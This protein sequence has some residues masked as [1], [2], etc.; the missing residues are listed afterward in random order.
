MNHLPHLNQVVGGASYCDTVAYHHHHHHHPMQMS[1]QAARSIPSTVNNLTSL[2][3]S[4]ANAGGGPL[5]S[6]PQ[7]H[8]LNM[9]Q[10]TTNNYQ[11]QYIAYH[12]PPPYHQ[13]QSHPAQTQIPPHNHVYSSTGAATNQPDPLD[14]QPNTRQPY[15]ATSAYGGL[16]AVSYEPA[17]HGIAIGGHDPMYGMKPSTINTQS[18]HH[19]NM[20]PQTHQPIPTHQTMPPHHSHYHPYATAAQHH[21]PQSTYSPNHISNLTSVTQPSQASLIGQADENSP[22]EYDRKQTQQLAPGQT[23]LLYG[24]QNQTNQPAHQTSSMHQIQQNDD[25]TVPAYNQLQPLHRPNQAS[26]ADHHQNINNGNAGNNNHNCNGNSNSV[27]NHHHQPPNHQMQNANN[28]Q[29]SNN[30]VK[31]EQSRTPNSQNSV[32]NG[33]PTPP[34]NQTYPWMQLRRNAPKAAMVKREDS[35]GM[36]SRGECGDIPPGSHSLGATCSPSE[37]S[38]ASSTTSSSIIGSGNLSGSGLCNGSGPSH[39]PM[40]PNGSTTGS[41]GMVN[42]GASTSR[43]QQQTT[44]TNGNVGRTNFT[45]SQL[46]ELEKEFHTSRYLTRARRIEIAQHLNLNETQVKI[47]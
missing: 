26:S 37:L 32:T 19:Y 40:T 30:L 12:E 28:R 8:E 33:Q 39:L 43:N 35:M 5:E 46:T 42:Q 14:Q 10:T 7:P 47:W 13:H 17:S 3:S 29:H 38:S 23:I 45:N 1:H 15:H 34:G 18:S 2:D 22:E 44:T 36:M 9:S 21:H 4:S 41:N 16:T 24:N 11:N 27:N 20:V 6:T 25:Y 31:I